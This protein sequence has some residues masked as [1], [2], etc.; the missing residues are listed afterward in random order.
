MEPLWSP[1]V[2][3]T[4]KQSTL[5]WPKNPP[6]TAQLLA[7]ACDRPPEPRHGKE[8]STEGRVTDG[9]ARR[10]RRRAHILSTSLTGSSSSSS[11]RESRSQPGSQDGSALSQLLDR[12]LGNA[13]EFVDERG[14]AREQAVLEADRAIA[15]LILFEQ[16]ESDQTINVRGRTAVRRKTT[17]DCDLALRP[18]RSRR[19]A[20]EDEPQHEPPRPRAKD[21][22]SGGQCLCASLSSGHRVRNYL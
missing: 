19:L 10:K 5:Q 20:V 13:F 9:T 15:P 1:A 4:G 18:T 22:V 2:A 3:T 21:P 7:N 14:H 17:R 12:H 11:S 16:S 8:G 6:E